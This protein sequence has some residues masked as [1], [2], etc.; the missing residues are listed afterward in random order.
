MFIKPKNMPEWLTKLAFFQA[1][2]AFTGSMYL[3]D[4]AGYPPCTL[5]W[6]QRILMFPLVL[7]FMVAIIKRD[8]KIYV[9]VLPLTILGWIISL[10]HNFLYYDIIP[11]LSISPCQN[12]VSCTTKY[13][14][15]FGVFTIPLLALIAFTII[16]ALM[17]YSWKQ[18]VKNSVSQG[19]EDLL[20]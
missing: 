18:Q 5:C 20:K 17:L 6:Y 9:Y 10:Y 11:E 12:G 8:W 7:L 15:I 2:V 13:I 1:A 4:I 16:N 19:K 3:S 14:E